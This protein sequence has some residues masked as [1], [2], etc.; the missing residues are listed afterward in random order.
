M[1]QTFLKKHKIY[2]D[3]GEDRHQ[4]TAEEL[5][6]YTEQTEWVEFVLSQEAPQHLKTNWVK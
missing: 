3:A 2:V 4:H 5:D 1:P 6:S